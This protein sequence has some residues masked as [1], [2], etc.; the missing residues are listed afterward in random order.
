MP[1]LLK[2]L[3][4][5][6]VKNFIIDWNVKFPIDRWYRQKYGIAFNSSQHRK[7]SLLDILIDYEED[8]L[9]NTMHSRISEK[10]K[11]KKEYLS[12]GIFLQKQKEVKENLSEQEVDDIFDN[13]DL[14]SLNRNIISEEKDNEQ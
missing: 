8:F 1:N 4:L 11:R 14:D 2:K 6:E 12:T 7:V 13:I 3:S 5:K 10:D 9:F